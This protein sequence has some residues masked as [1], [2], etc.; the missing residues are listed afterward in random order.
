MLTTRNGDER[1]VG[2]VLAIGVDRS[3]RRMG[4]ATAL[5]L[6]AAKYFKEK[7]VSY[8]ECEVLEHN[9]EARE[10]VMSLGFEE[11][12]VTIYGVRRDLFACMH[13]SPFWCRSSEELIITFT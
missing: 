1:R 2:V 5:M 9:I 12:G 6:K 8:V 3:F 13:A 10:L 7:G 11:V 4:I